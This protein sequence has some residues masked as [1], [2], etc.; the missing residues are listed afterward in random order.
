MAWD[1]DP[2]DN[3]SSVTGDTLLTD[4]NS[5]DCNVNF[6]TYRNAAMSIPRSPK[7]WVQAENQGDQRIVNHG[8]LWIATEGGV[9]AGTYGRILVKWKIKFYRPN[10]DPDVATIGYS[11]SI[12]ASTGS[13][14]SA[15]YPWGDFTTIINTLPTNVSPTYNASI[16]TFQSMIPNTSTPAS[17]IV[18]QS[19]G[20]YRVCFNRTGT[21]I[22]VSAYTPSGS[23]GCVFGGSGST[24]AGYPFSAQGFMAIGNGGSTASMG[25]LD[26]NAT[27]GGYIYATGDSGVTHTTSYVTVYR[28]PATNLPPPPSATPQ[29]ESSEIRRLKQLLSTMS[30]VE[31]KSAPLVQNGTLSEQGLIHSVPSVAGEPVVNYASST[32]G[33]LDIGP[34]DVIVLDADPQN[35]NARINTAVQNTIPESECSNVLRILKFN[36]SLKELANMPKR[37][38]EEA[39]VRI[40]KELNVRP[41]EQ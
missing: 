19:P 33:Q 15:T 41:L 25:W 31:R 40:A 22:G 4:L 5:M 18:F 21:A 20:Q 6:S 39:V 7:L 37:S 16:V 9:A 10:L 38:L 26:V 23:S 27:A 28:Y 14:V 30:L 29:L 2:A 35:V 34:V 12:S 24:S 11:S 32:A 3:Y 13:Y 8:R 1:A 36:Y 17:V